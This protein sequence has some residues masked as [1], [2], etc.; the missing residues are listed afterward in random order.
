MVKMVCSCCGGNNIDMNSKML[1]CGKIETFYC[2]N[3]KSFEE[4]ETED[5]YKR[6]DLLCNV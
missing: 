3:C 5:E 6:I 2:Y 1:L 4:L